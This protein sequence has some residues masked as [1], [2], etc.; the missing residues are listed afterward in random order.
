MIINDFAV[1]ADTKL[2]YFRAVIQNSH[3]MRA[4]FDVCRYLI[5]SYVSPGRRSRSVGHIKVRSS[6][7]TDL[8]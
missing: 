8:N 5:I 2:A 6:L 3:D 1:F 4:A 7:T